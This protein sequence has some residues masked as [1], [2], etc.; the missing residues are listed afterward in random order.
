MSGLDQWAAHVAEMA[1]QSAGDASLSS[2]SHE[3]IIEFEAG[4]VIVENEVTFSREELTERAKE[5][6]FEEE[7]NA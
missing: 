7:R 6:A 5:M 1:A 3:E 4:R 2:W